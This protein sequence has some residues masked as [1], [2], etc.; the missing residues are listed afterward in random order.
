[1]SIQNLNPDSLVLVVFDLDGTLTESKQ[2]LDREMAKLLAELLKNKY[3]A[4]T[5]GASFFQFEQQFLGY[6]TE[7]EPNLS[8]LYLL[9]TSGARL[10]C[11]Q[12]GLW[13]AV[14]YEELSV[15]EKDK[16]MKAFLLQDSEGINV[17]GF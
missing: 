7:G 8:H 4:V 15:A 2:P 11:F 16:I 10:Y 9:P 5:S 3:V 17:M 13:K 14:Y 6:L 1:M 12:N